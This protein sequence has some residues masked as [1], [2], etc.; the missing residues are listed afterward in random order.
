MSTP[1][2]FAIGFGSSLALAVLSLS[3]SALADDDKKYEERTTTTTTTTTTGAPTMGTV[4]Q[5]G[6][7]TIVVSPD[8]GTPVTYSTK[9][10]TTYV[11]EDGNP[12]AVETVESGAPVI[13]YTD[14][15]GGKNA[16]K[17]VV[18]KHTVKKEDDDD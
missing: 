2:R 8:G 4:R 11:D 18:K 3:S 7:N 16:T 10:T 6:P 12:V 15:S 5:V 9:K 17:V 14:K 13:V 1:F